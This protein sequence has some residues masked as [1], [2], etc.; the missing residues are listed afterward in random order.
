MKSV[1][2]IGYLKGSSNTT[3]VDSESPTTGTLCVLGGAGV[4]K[5]LHVGEFVYAQGYKCRKGVPGTF[6]GN[7][8][9]FYW[10]SPNVECW[11]DWSHVGDIAFKDWVQGNFKPIEYEPN[12][13]AYYSRD[14][15][16]TLISPLAS[17]DYVYSKV[18]AGQTFA[19]FSYLQ[20]YYKPLTWE[21][22]LSNYYNRDEVYSKLQS[23]QRY[24]NINWTPDLTPYSLKTE[25]NTLASSVYTKVESDGR[26]KSIEWLPDLSNF[27]SRD[28]V[29]SI[30]SQFAPLEFVYTKSAANQ[31]FK[32]IEY[33]PN[34]SA[35]A[36]K[37]ALDDYLPWQVALDFYASKESV[38][39]KSETD[40]T[41]VSNTFFNEFTLGVYTRDQADYTFAKF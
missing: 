5:N 38:Y 19:T 31:R 23:D 40:Q 6:F 33:E 20:Q 22:N 39:T 28:E 18:E 30:T 27:Y 1:A 11:I 36:L 32:P 4:S 16:N 2:A 7:T 3:I 10:E 34:L 15:I 8:F 41:F 24:K 9:N 21:P 26:Y 14:E 12:L 17:R 37:T 13:S 25:L 29:N 35:Y